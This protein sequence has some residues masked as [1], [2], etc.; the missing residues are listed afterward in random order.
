MAT[1]MLPE[2]KFFPLH[3]VFAPA[4]GHTEQAS[5]L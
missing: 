1:I 4:L 3:G 5:D 2:V